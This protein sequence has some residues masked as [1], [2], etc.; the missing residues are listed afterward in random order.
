MS[1]L[2][3]MHEFLEGNT[4]SDNQ[5]HYFL[6]LEKPGKPAWWSNVIVRGTDI[7]R[8][9]LMFFFKSDNIYLVGFMNGDGT[10]YY[11]SDTTNMFT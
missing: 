1:F 11:T 7:G 9:T 3:V 10:L 8:R 5:G 4:E 6:P 2:N